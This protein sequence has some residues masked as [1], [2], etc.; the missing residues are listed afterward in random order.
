MNTNEAPAFEIHDHKTKNIL[1]IY[2]D[3]RVEG[4]PPGCEFSIINRI[5]MLIKRAEQT[6]PIEL[7]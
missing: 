7:G 4:M 1:R 6:K 2:R 5:P 3:G